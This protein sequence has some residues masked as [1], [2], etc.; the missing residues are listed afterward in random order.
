MGL[1][2]F[3]SIVGIIAL[4]IGVWGMVQLHNETKVSH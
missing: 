1:I 4:C 3:L 2:V